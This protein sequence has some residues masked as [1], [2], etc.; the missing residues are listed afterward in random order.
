V[1]AAAA[2]HGLAPRNGSSPNVSVVGYT[3]AGGLPLLGRTL[4]WAADHVRALEVVTWDG[5]LHRATAESDPELFRV[6]LGS[7]GALGVV[8]AAEFDLVPLTHV[9]GGALTFDGADAAAV[10]DAWLAWTLAAPREATSSLAMISMPDLPVI[11]EPL[12]GRDTVSV[13]LALLGDE[14]AGIELVRPL[15]EAAPPLIDTL[16]VLPW[17]DSATI[18][19]D[20]PGAHRYHGT[21]VM[22]RSLDAEGMREIVRGAGPGGPVSTVVQ[23]NHL[24]GAFAE[25]AAAPNV[26]GHREAAYVLRLLSVVGGGGVSPIEQAHE[27]VV[28]ALGSRVLGRALGFQFGRHPRAQWEACFDPGDLPAITALSRESATMSAPM[29]SLSRARGG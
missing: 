11:P 13:R 25:P 1:V 14:K 21:G 22:L 7:G 24:G 3:L 29:T 15:R 16:R 6:L 5:H 2:G 23:V 12:R 18:A 10:T 26:V 27:S 8:T 9:F 28:S 4:G 19:S 17:T 20:P